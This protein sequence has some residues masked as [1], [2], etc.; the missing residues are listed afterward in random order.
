MLGGTPDNQTGSSADDSSYDSEDQLLY[1]QP[2][3]H[4]HTGVRHVTGVNPV[5]PPRFTSVNAMAVQG[6]K[7]KIIDYEDRVRN[8]NQIHGLD[9]KPLQVLFMLKDG[10]AR[11][12]IEEILKPNNTFDSNNTSHQ[13]A[14]RDYMFQKQNTPGVNS[15][16]KID[17]FERE[18]RKIRI[19]MKDDS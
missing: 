11:V 10:L 17:T 19:D 14:I 5:K 3:Q 13:R 1:G 18:M 8:H 6:A 12:L 4:K 2:A 9:N 7:R 16:I 15:H